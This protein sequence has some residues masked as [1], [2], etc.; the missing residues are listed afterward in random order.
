[1]PFETERGGVACYPD[2]LPPLCLKCGVENP[3]RITR[4]L[5]ALYRADYGRMLIRSIK[6]RL[7]MCKRCERRWDSA[8]MVAMAGA[9]SPIVLGVAAYKLH[10][11]PAWIGA[12][13]VLAIVA[14]IFVIMK[15]L[16]WSLKVAGVEHDAMLELRGVP[17]GVRSAIVEAGTKLV[18]A[19]RVAAPPASWP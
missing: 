2:E 4:N 11:P 10:A 16:T 14:G 3:P 17:A 6:A 5:S 7:P 8:L 19:N 15:A 1:M 18:V 9:F 13:V 12:T